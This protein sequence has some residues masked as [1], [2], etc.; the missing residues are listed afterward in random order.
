M[1]HNMLDQKWSA[2]S[3]LRFAFP[4]I[5]MMMFMGLYTMVDTVFVAQFVNT[6]A[7]SAINIVCPVVHI[8]VG[9]GTMIAAGGNAIVSR[10]MGAGEQ[11]EA[12]ENFTL[13]ILTGAAVGFLIFLGGTVWVEEI[14]RALGASGLLVPY[15]KDYLTALLLFAPANVLQTL[16][17]NLFVTA[18][19]PGLGFGLSLLAGAANIALDYIFIVPCGLGIRGA[20]LGTGFGYLIPAVGGLIYFA[21][22]KGTLSFTRPKL[23]WAVIRESCFNGSSEMVSQLAAAVT[24]FLFNRTMMNLLGED[25]VAAITI[26][27]YSQFLLNTLY[28]GYAIGIAPIIGFNYGNGNEV[29]QKQV[30]SISIRFIAA[31]SVLIFA[32]SRFGG[33]YI[34]RLFADDTSEVYRI[35][36][37]GFAMFSYSFLFCGLNQFASAMFTALSNGRVSAILSFL[38]TFGLLAGGIVLLPRVWGLAGVWLAAPVAEGVMFAVSVA[39]LAAYRSRY[40]Y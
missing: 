8:T 17:A 21:D 9:M 13:L 39:C 1:D 30:F 25:G 28:I 40:A 20:A 7:L 27:I 35:A 10:N 22:R 18:G 32:A 12:K 37:D 19:N 5:F 3:L 15:C 14:V 23:K 31:A 11:Q 29:R 4:T 36:A 33:S 38:R 34:V 26:I 2:G 6:D 16:A 24:T